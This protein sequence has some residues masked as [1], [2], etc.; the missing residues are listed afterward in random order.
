MS[1]SFRS[2]AQRCGA[3]LFDRVVSGASFLT[4]GVFEC[5]L[6]HRRPVAVLCIMYKIG[7]KFVHPLCGPLPVLFCT[8]AGYSWSRGALIAH[9]YS[10]A[11]PSCRTAQYLRIFIHH[12][13]SCNDL[14]DIVFDGVRLAGLKTGSMHYSSPEL[15]SP[16]LSSTDFSCF[17]LWVG[18]VWLGLLL[19]TIV[20]YF[21]EY[22]NYF[23]YN[24]IHIFIHVKI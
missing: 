2:T 11:P 13:V 24:E 17:N 6:S 20:N 15:P 16:I 1:C 7:S 18:F 10:Y 21:Q 23:I 3:R 8:N 14:F 5:N 12:S 22:I 9:R 19:K 4:G